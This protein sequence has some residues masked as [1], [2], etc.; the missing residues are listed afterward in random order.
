MAYENEKRILL[1]NAPEYVSNLVA[2]NYF[3][4]DVTDSG[5]APPALAWTFFDT[6]A[7]RWIISFRPD[8]AGMSP[9]AQEALWRHEVGHIAFAHFG[10]ETCKPDDPIRSRIEQL[11]VGDIQV[12]YYLLEEPEVLAE[13]GRCSLRVAERLSGELPQGPG[14]LDP[15]ILLPEIGL[16]VQEHPYDVIHAYLHQKIDEKNDKGNGSGNWTQEALNAACGGIINGDELDAESGA[17]LSAAVVGAVSDFG[18]E[19]SIGSIRLRES[20]LPEWI[21]SLEAFARAIV[22]IVMADTRSHT[23]PQDIYKAYDVHMPTMR[24]RWA[25]KANQVCFLVDTSGSMYEGL[26]YV[27]PVV[28][29]LTQHNISVRLIAGDTRVTF[30]ELLTPSTPLPEAVVGGGGTEITPL[31]ERAM[32]YNPRSVVFF[33]DGY[34]PKFPRNEGDIPTLWV[35]C[36]VD[37]P[38]G[39]KA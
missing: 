4:C 7:K 33:S 24:P 12:N 9:G 5:D 17:E 13:V 23:R 16:T 25:Y 32:E 15:R 31:W 20:N 22:E 18:S 38:F 29:Y 8:A 19:A 36:Q 27:M 39:S 14:F 35:G 3:H 30:D 37:V 34:V 21:D 6:K 2:G 11:Q 28:Q 1:Q 26:Q 10:K